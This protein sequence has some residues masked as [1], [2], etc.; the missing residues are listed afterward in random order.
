MGVRGRAKAVREHDIEGEA[1][2]INA[3]Y[4]TLWAAP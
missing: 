2:R 4:R 1:R 3:V